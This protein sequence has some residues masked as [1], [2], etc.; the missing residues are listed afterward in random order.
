[1]LFFFSS[2]NSRDMISNR[3][4]NSRK[5]CAL[6]KVVGITFSFRILMSISPVADT[7]LKALWSITVPWLFIFTAAI[8]TISS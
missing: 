5:T 3:G 1:M 4:M 7:S 6:G 8:C 2:D